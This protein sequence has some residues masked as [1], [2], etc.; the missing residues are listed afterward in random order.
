MLSFAA[1]YDATFLSNALH[2]MIKSLKFNYTK[3]I[4]NLL[5]I[6]RKKARFVIF[7]ESNRSSSTR[8]VSNH[9]LLERPAFSSTSPWLVRSVYK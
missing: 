2:N 4:V 7:A 5:F 8:L 1:M 3:E 9:G 6:R